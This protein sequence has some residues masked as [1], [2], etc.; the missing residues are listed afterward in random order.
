MQKRRRYSVC[1]ATELT[2]GTLKLVEVNG[3]E[4]GIA[5]VG[6]Q[7]VAYRNVCPHQ[8]A[9]IC[10]GRVGGTTLP[11]APGEYVY[12]KDGLVLHCP[13]HGWQFDLVSGMALSHAQS[14]APVKAQIDKDM[15]SVYI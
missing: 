4:I 13:W 9:P 10:R 12:G 11:S 8:G 14:L 7:V 6:D 1:L 3:T 15:V 5:K 2:P